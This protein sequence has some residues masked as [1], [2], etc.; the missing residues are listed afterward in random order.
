MKFSNHIVKIFGFQKKKLSKRQIFM[1]SRNKQ[2]QN[3]N[4]NEINP[5][6]FFDFNFT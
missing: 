2:F 4:R 6:I 3:E 1:K 5:E